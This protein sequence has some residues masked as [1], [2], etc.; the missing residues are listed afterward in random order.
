MLTYKY[1]CDRCGTVSEEEWAYKCPDGWERLWID[2]DTDLDGGGTHI[3]LCDKCRERPVL[4][5]IDITGER[6]AAHIPDA[7]QLA[8]LV[9]GVPADD[10][11]A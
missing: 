3:Y 2:E 6:I 7:E 10:V 5:A 4:V 9:A 1:S 8:A 11:F